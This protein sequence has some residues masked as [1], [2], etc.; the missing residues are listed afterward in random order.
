MRRAVTVPVEDRNCS[1]NRLAY[2]SM[3]DFERIAKPQL[4]PLMDAISG[5][6]GDQVIQLKDSRDVN[7]NTTYN[8][9]ISQLQVAE[10]QL[11]SYIQCIQK[12]ILQRNDFSS[13][14][15]N[16]QQEVEVARKTAAQRK[17]TASEAKERVSDVTNPYT[18]TTWWETWFPL[19]RPIQKDNVP[20]LL[21]VS[22]F[23]LVFSLGIFL[24][25]AGM[26]LKLTSVEAITNSFTKSVNSRKYP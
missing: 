1:T 3:A 22:I 23:M 26:E 13:R 17:E 14:L 6:S 5:Y 10:N 24:R 19:G 7:Q 20:V 12:D 16:L 21:S 8:T 18:K 11:N 15:Y 9:L 4:Q 2:K 25:F